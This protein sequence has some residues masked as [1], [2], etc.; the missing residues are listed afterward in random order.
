[1]TAGNT[2]EETRVG[3]RECP[4]FRRR[5]DIEPS[6]T[7][8]WSADETDTLTVEVVRQRDGAFADDELK[9]PLGGDSA[10][11][12]DL[13]GSET[14]SAFTEDARVAVGVADANVLIDDTDTSSDG[15]PSSRDPTPSHDAGPN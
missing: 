1:M 14:D 8:Q 4:R 10:E 11:T 12:H 9:A 3:D 5:L 6:D 7:L 15:C 2:P 13:A